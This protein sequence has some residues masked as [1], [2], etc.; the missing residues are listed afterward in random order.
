MKEVKRFQSED[1]KL[2]D[3]A[4]KCLSYEIDLTAVQTVMSLLNPTPKDDHCE[5]ANGRGF[6][7]QDI[8]LVEKCMR[9]VINIA[10]IDL[11]DKKE[12]I[13]E[14]P[15]LYRNSVIGR[16]LSDSDKG[17][18]Y[19][20]WCRFMCMDDIGREFGQPYFSAHPEKAEQIEI[21]TGAKSSANSAYNK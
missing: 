9:I 8:Q 19:S 12:E 21:K 17:F 3:S 5:F 4:E 11:K 15:F 10:A 20:A 18:L 13:M 16:Y 1:G 14:H 7:R 2:F 6:V